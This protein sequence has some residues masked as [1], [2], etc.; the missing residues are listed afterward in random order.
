M[1]HRGRSGTRGEGR[2]TRGRSVEN[3]DETPFEFQALQHTYLCAS[4]K[5]T[6]VSGLQGCA[7][8]DKLRDAAEF[9]GADAPC[10]CGRA[11]R[12]PTHGGPAEEREVIT[13]TE[14][15][16][17]IYKRAPTAVEVDTVRAAAGVAAPRASPGRPCG[18]ACRGAGW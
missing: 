10:A 3:T 9:T 14:E 17:R 1:R 8:L 16:D 12:P 2:L 15:T 7:F 11:L 5:D 6:R 4:I 18:W 13:F